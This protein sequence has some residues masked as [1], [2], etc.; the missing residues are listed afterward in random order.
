MKIKEIK[1][2]LFKIINKDQKDHR[3]INNIKIE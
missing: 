3:Y 2:N 1:F